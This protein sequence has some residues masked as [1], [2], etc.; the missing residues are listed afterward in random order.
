MKIAL[1]T[2]SAGE[3]DPFTP[4]NQTLSDEFLKCGRET[5]LVPLDNQLIN[6]LE[7]LKIS[8][9][10]FA[11]T[12]QGL[13]SRIARDN[14][15]MCI[16]DELD[17]PLF[18]M[19]GDHPS[20]MPANHY[21][22]ASH[23]RHLYTASSFNIFANRHF[24]RLHPAQMIKPPVL[25][26]KEIDS[27]LDGNYFVLIKNLDDTFNTLQEWQ[28]KIPSSILKILM[29]CAL[30][31]MDSL[32]N[33]AATDHHALI[34]E[35]LTTEGVE[36]PGSDGKNDTLFYWMHQELNKFYRNV[37]SE[38]IISELKDI[39]LKVFGRGWD[40]H[41]SSS[42]KLHNF[43]APLRADESESLYYSRYGIV[44]VAPSF[45][46]LHDRTLRAIAC[47][48]SFII[49]SN[50]PHANLL[51]SKPENIFFNSLNGNLTHRAMQII[52]N[53]Q[54]H[55]EQ[56]I[57]FSENYQRWASHFELLRTIEISR[58]TIKR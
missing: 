7:E 57:E 37:L 23:V 56:C 43:H 34:D 58:S 16:W 1:L 51:T 40:R 11:I 6:R 42:N 30:E 8:G 46:T 25:N 53:P 5:I 12:W 54:K 29:N 19:H 48:S 9:I 41:A 44:D 24:K 17:I 33:R 45:D 21:A 22:L 49:G 38:H 27:A 20:Q 52:D 14:S 39:P 36:I 13:G 2:W 28:K 15:N 32:Q 31:I 4:F 55:H 50:W 26:R 35:I 47:K 10:D 3:N 18:C